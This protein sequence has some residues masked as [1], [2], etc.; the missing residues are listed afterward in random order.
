MT[1]KEF[2]ANYY[3]HDSLIDK[4]EILEN[5]STIILWIDFAFWMQEWYN[6]NDPE[7]GI[8]KVTFHGV[9]GYTIPENVNWN[10]ISI[11]N[12]DMEE[13][14]VKFALS[15]DMTD[16]YLEISINADSVSVDVEEN[17]NL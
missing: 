9:S 14:G 12:M 11:L 16:D 8:I 10:E 6:E 3:M 17:G 7:T 15:N 13:D 2:V 4:A 5:G 1:I